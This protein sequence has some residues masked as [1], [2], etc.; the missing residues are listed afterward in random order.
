M[1]Y[2]AIA[3]AQA[4]IID[5]LSALCKQLISE[6]SQYKN[7]EEEERKLRELEGTDR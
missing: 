3:E 1:I 7:C 2:Q 5:E 4:R 6:L